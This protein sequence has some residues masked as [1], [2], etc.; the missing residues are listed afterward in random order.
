MNPEHKKFLNECAC[1]AKRF[2]LLYAA[3]TGLCSVDSRN[4]KAA[5]MLADNHFLRY[6]GDSF[7]VVDR[8]DSQFPW[9]LVHMENGVQFFCI[10]EKNPKE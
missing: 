6:F 10:T 8:K 4:G 1:M 7:E 3:D 9:E 5:V 2:N